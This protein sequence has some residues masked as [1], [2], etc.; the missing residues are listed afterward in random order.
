M[1][2]P[3]PYTGANKELMDCTRNALPKDRY[4]ESKRRS[5]NWERR[6]VE[7]ASF[8]MVLRTHASLHPGQGPHEFVSEYHGIITCTDDETGQSKNVGRVNADF[9]LDHFEGRTWHGWH[10][11]VGLVFAAYHFLTREPKARPDPFD[12]SFL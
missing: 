2:L 5:S 8:D 12:S 9:G 3:I 1:T 4:K 7:M 11:H 6:R 10:H